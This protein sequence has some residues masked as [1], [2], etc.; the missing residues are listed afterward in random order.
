MKDAIGREINYLRISITDRCNF[1]CLY[2]MPEK[3]M[4]SKSHMDILRF[5]EIL[6]FV[7][8]VAPLGISKVRVTG[9]EPLV[10]KGVVD[11][12]RE[13]RAIDGIRDISMTTNGSLLSFMARDLKQA[14]LDRVNIS[15]DS[16][17][18]ERFHKI[19]R[20][21]KL[22]DVLCGIES[23]LETGLI[24][25]KINCVMVKGF[26]DDEIEDFVNLTMNHSIYIRFIELMP[27]GEK[28]WGQGRYISA[29]EIK[30]LIKEKLI[31]TGAPA[32]AGPAVYYRAPGAVGAVGFITPI[33]R[34]FCDACNR[35]RLTADG[36]LKPCLESDLEIDI[37]T[38]LRE[39]KGDEHLRRLF[40]EALLKKPVCHHM[41][42]EENAG[43]FRKMWQI[44]G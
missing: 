19:T 34:H 40:K 27:L 26:N 8:A 11:F 15:L 10:R 31:P 7:K 44:G 14:G 2:C 16:L 32:G 43:H 21:G 36:K 13:L 9:G 42:P 1:R 25:V 24:P 38:A 12:I 5:E 29:D 37:K 18:S 23:A 41:K 20:W 30:A 35:V 22:S 33:S 6:E 28:G 39:K 17:K 3:G 4:E